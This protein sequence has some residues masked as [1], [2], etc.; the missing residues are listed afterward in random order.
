MIAKSSGP[1]SAGTIVPK[2][3]V[4]K[5]IASWSWSQLVKEPSVFFQFTRS[6]FEFVNLSLWSGPWKIPF[7]CQ[8]ID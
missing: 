3:T 2:A 6:R 5:K 1:V 8:H 4:S 7:V